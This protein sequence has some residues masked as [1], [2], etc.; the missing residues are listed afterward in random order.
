MANHNSREQIVI[1]GSP[2]AVIAVSQ[3]A[4]SN[5]A[6]AI[7]LKVSGAWHSELIKGAEAEFAAFLETIDFTSPTH[8]IIHNVTADSCQ[9]ASE[10]R[11]LMARQLCSPVRWYDTICRL[12][13]EKVEIFIEVGPGRVLAGLLKKI[14]PPEYDYQGLQRRQHENAGRP[15][16]R[17]VLNRFSG[18]HGMRFHCNIPHMVRYG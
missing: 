12:M 11:Q 9:E 14:V 8:Q 15:G 6:R 2:E 17:I 10:I 13:A 3:V 18:K 5:G 7:P 16:V 4:K 1:T